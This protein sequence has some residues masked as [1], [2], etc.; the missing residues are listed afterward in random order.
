MPGCPYFIA[1]TFG[2]LLSG[3]VLT[4][5]SSENAFISKLEEKPFTLICTY[6]LTFILFYG[7]LNVEPNSNLQYILFI[8]SCVSF[9]AILSNL[10]KKLDLAGELTEILTNTGAIFLM[11]TFIGFIDNQNMLSSAFYLSGALIALIIAMIINMLFRSKKDK[12]SSVSTWMTRLGVFLFTL[13][14]GYDIQVLK[15]HAVSC[16]KNP[17]YINESAGLYLDI[18]NVFA[19]LGVL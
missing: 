17:A 6:L 9:G 2:H 16:K 3:L 10:V 5:V 11:M 14:I 1:N 19:G 8:L 7:V 18:V 13:Y 15:S 12:K 4:A